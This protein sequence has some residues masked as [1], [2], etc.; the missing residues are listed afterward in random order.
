MSGRSTIGFLTTDSGSAGINIY[1][2][3]AGAGTGGGGGGGDGGEA[4]D[5]LNKNLGMYQNL[6][7][8]VIDSLTAY[9][10]YFSGGNFSDLNNEFTTEKFNKLSSN[11]IN[12]TMLSAVSEDYEYNPTLFR[13][14][15]ESFHR[16]L[17]GLQKSVL[18]NTEL[19]NTT[20][21]LL[22]TQEKADILDDMAKLRAYLEEK[23][24]QMF[25]CDVSTQLN[26]MAVLKP[27]YQ[28]YIDLYGLPDGLIFESE[29]M[30][31][32]ISDL[33]A[34]GVLTSEDVF[35]DNYC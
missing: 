15:R 18:Q 31:E 11:L 24:N 14:Y 12:T 32:I 20:Q 22:T 2:T 17:E 4:F 26:E 10:T 29:K 33:I 3:F 25:F 9:L 21:L 6:H 13:L 1:Q 5:E 19:E 7:N 8:K 27:Q 28:R 23:Q 16:V 30:A 35:G 34:E